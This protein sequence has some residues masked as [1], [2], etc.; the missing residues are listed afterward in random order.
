MPACWA[1]FAAVKK[2]GEFATIPIAPLEMAPWTAVEVRVGFVSS[3]T[4]ERLI[5]LPSTP[6]S[7]FCK[8]TRAHTSLLGVAELG[9]AAGPVSEEI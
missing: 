7:A 3:S 8:S 6:P 9:C 4:T 1:Y 5:F 2:S